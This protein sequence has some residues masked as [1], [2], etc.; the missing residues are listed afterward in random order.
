MLLTDDD[1]LRLPLPQ[2]EAD[3]VPTQIPAFRVRP[4]NNVYLPPPWRDAIRE[5]NE[6]LANPTSPL[7]IGFAAADL[8]PGDIE[9]EARLRQVVD[10][11]KHLFPGEAGW[12][13]AWQTL[14]NGDLSVWTLGET[15]FE[16]VNWFERDLPTPTPRRGR[17]AHVNQDEKINKLLGLLTGNGDPHTFSRPIT[18]KEAQKRLGMDGKTFNRLLSRLRKEQ[19][20]DLRQSGRGRSRTF[21]WLNTQEGHAEWP[22]WPPSATLTIATP[23]P[24]TCRRSCGL[25]NTWEYTGPINDGHEAWTAHQAECPALRAA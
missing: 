3:E 7:A 6:L 25:C 22:R 12:H 10:Q 18:Y 16:A 5:I 11:H 23:E 20:I 9:I 13:V 1:Q 4:P 21:E 19:G 15:L 14:C 8:E 17:R 2:I 24:A